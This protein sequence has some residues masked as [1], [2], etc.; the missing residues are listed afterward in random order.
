L[1]VLPWDVR[2]LGGLGSVALA[3]LVNNDLW[4]VQ[5]CPLGGTW[6]RR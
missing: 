3:L 1:E 2:G 5:G 6:C 4:L